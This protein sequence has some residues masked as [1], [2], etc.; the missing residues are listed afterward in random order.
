MKRFTWWRMEQNAPHNAQESGCRT[1]SILQHE[2]RSMSHC[3]YC[4]VVEVEEAYIS[5][6]GF[7]GIVLRSPFSW[8]GLNPF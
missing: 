4:D 5:S 3:P 8:Q 2:K 6:Y 7:V 1:C